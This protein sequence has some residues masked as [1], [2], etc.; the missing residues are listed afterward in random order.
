MEIARYRTFIR[1]WY[2]RREGGIEPGPG[3]KTAVDYG[4][5]FSEAQR[6]CKAYNDGNRPGPLSRKMEF[7]SY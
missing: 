7:E 6:A 3:R 5:T 2:V 4:L 1:N